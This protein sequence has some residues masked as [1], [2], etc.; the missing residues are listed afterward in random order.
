MLKKGER[1]KRGDVRLLWKNARAKGRRGK[2]VAIQCEMNSRGRGAQW[3]DRFLSAGRG[4]KEE[5]EER[6]EGDVPDRDPAQEAEKKKRG[7][8]GRGERGGRGVF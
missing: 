4:K 3:R 8:E 7:G 5:K 1:E 2:G 6:E